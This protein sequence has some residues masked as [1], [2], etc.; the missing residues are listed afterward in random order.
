M[1]EEITYNLGTSLT[2]RVEMYEM[3]RNVRMDWECPCSAAS[4]VGATL[5]IAQKQIT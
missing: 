5:A 1:L 4:K 2:C 3:Y